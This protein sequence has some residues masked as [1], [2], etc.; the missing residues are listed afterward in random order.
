ML[1]GSTLLAAVWGS[2]TP[3]SASTAPGQM[4]VPVINAETSKQ[5]VDLQAPGGKPVPSVTWAIA[6]DIVRFDPA[7]AYGDNS[8]PVLSQGCEGLLR[9]NANGGLIPNLASSWGSPN[10]LTYVYHVRKNVQ[11]WDGSP[12][13]PDDVVYSMRRIMNPATH[14]YAS[15]YYAN[16]KSI[17]RTGPWQITV[18]LKRPDR[19]WKYVPAMS[20]TGAVISKAFALA[21][22]T[23]LG[24]PGV[25]V[26]CTGPF[27]LVRWDRG[28]Q[29]VLQ[30]FGGYWRPAG[31]A[32]I[33]KL[34]FKIIPDPTALVTALNSGA[35]DGT[36][37]GFD[38]REA[39]LLRGPL[40]L[41]KSDS[42][43][44][45]SL[46]FNTTRKPWNDV[47]VRQAFA[48]ALDR[49]AIV[50]SVYNTLG[51]STK[52]PIAPV[53]WTYSKSAYA[54]AFDAL[55]SYNP[56]L[57]KA[58]DLIAAAHAKG[59]VATLTIGSDTDLRVAL[60]VEEA[61]GQLGITLTLR[62]LAP[63][64]KAAMESSDGPKDF[65]LDLVVARS[66][67]PDPL[68]MLLRAFNPANAVSDVTMYGNTAV[69]R[70]LLAAQ[71]STNATD[72]AANVIKAQAQIM[73]DV[74]VLPYVAPDTIVPLNKRLT[75]F[76]PTFFTY[77]TPWA[78]DLS[79]TR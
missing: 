78:A 51:R 60:F 58:Q 17:S 64:R 4:K 8:T 59:T 25:G 55:P 72:E 28:K 71:S 41:V 9:F 35:V 40:N 12:M 23:D 63:A 79:G 43:T 52:S 14:A 66:D 42:D 44:T 24:K 69:T 31:R 61:A 70:S 37:Y 38:G 26:L 75:G 47:R 76:V 27:K 6:G 73:Q 34:T 15:S 19:Q 18:K 1:L 11:F 39:Q 3:S 16:V 77:W 20:A 30:R 22:P 2:S 45:T 65:D 57:E 36:L 53:L 10:P 68:N 74:P 29:I 5:A 7:F 62:Q 54:N 49:T 56:D 21:H 48:Y 32:K 67:T 13:T 33:A 46:A 50:T